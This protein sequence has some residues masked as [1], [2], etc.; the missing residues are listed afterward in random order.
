MT[1]CSPASFSFFGQHRTRG[2][3]NY[4]KSGIVGNVE[5]AACREG[6]NLSRSMIAEYKLLAARLQDFAARERII[7]LRDFGNDEALA[8]RAS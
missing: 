5:S 2:P 4:G 8:F 7:D 3:G 6:R 1:Q